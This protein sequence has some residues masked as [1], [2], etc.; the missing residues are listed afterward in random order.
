[1]PLYFFKSKSTG[2]LRNTGVHAA[3]A[4]AARKKLKR[5]APSDAV[6][7]KVLKKE[8]KGGGWDRTRADGK[9]PSKSRLGKGRGYGPKRR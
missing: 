3:S 5:P 4:K 9:S 7:Y 8:P 6:V 2:K 1:M